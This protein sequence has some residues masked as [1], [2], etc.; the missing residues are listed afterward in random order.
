MEPS[1][2]K[3]AISTVAISLVVGIVG[4]TTAASRP[5]FA[6][7]H[8][9]DVLE[10]VASGMCFGIALAGLLRLWRGDGRP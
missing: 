9:V 1:R 7:Y 8:T 5:R 2:R 3:T 6:A 10:L 4:L